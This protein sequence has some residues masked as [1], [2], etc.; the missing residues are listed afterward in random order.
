[1]RTIK[2]QISQRIH[3]IWS[4]SAIVIRCL[5]SITPLVVIRNFQTLAS[6]VSEQAGLSH[7]WSQT[8]EDWFPRDA[9]HLRFLQLTVF[10]L[11]TVF[12]I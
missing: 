3:T 10:K 1:M 5:D 7:T 8:P 6:Y 4:D 2:T 9:A 12:H 11:V